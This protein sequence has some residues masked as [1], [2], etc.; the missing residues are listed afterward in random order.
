MF[1][2][3]GGDAASDN[4]AVPLRVRNLFTSLELWKW[5]PDGKNIIQPYTLMGQGDNGDIAG[6]VFVVHQ[7]CYRRERL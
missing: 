4:G 1:W 3:F 5:T 2:K 7:L 6:F